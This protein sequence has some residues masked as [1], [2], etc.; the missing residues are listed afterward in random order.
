MHNNPQFIFDCFKIFNPHVL[1]LFPPHSMTME[2]RPPPVNGLWPF[3]NALICTRRWR[4]HS[5]GSGLKYSETGQ[6]RKI[7]L[8]N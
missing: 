8:R 4:K 3:F 7:W 6:R 5:S 1:F 2:L